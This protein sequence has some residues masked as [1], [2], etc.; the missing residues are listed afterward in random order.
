MIGRVGVFVFSHER[1][2]GCIVH[3]ALDLPDEIR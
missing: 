1:N 3:G 2:R